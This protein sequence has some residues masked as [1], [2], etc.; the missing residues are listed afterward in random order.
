MRLN[1]RSTRLP[2]V[3]L[4]GLAIGNAGCDSSPD[5]EPSGFEELGVTQDEL[6]AALPSCSTAASSGYNSTTKLLTLTLGGGVS[7]VVIAAAGGKI[8]VNG[9]NCVSSA[10][11]SLTTLNVSKLAVTGTAANEKVIFDMLPGSFGTTILS[12]TGGVTVDMG[13]GTDSFMVRGTSA[14]DKFVAGVSAA[15]DTYFDLTNDTKADI[16][17]IGSDSFGISLLGGADTFTAV[18]GA[19]SATHLSATVS[20]LTPMTTG[21]TVYGGDGADTIQ[22]GDGDDVLYGG[23]GDDTFKSAATDDGSDKMF[24]E[25]GVDLVDYSN[26]STAVVVDIG[27]EY[28]TQ[29]G[30]VDLSTLTFGASGTVDGDDLVIAVD[31][32]MNVTVS[33]SAPADAAAVVSQINAAAGATVASLSGGSHL[34]LASTTK[35]ATSSIQVVSGT[36]GSLVDLGLT[37]A[38]KTLADADDGIAGENDDV[39]FTVEKVN[40]GSGNDTIYGS[41]ASNTINGNSGND[42]LGGGPGAASCASDVDVLN[43]GDGNDTFAMGS[44]KDCGDALNGGAGTDIADYQLRSGALTITIDMSA[45]DGEAMEGDKV[46]TDIEVVLGGSAGDTITGGMG[47]DEIHGG[48]GGDTLNGG[49]GNDTL[50]G[51]E[52]NDTLNGDAGDDLFVESGVDASYV[53]TVNSGAGDDVINGGLGANTVSYAL[54]TATIDV[55]LCSDPTDNVGLPT[56]TA[57]ACTDADGEGAE[58]DK[59]TNLQWVVGGDGDDNLTGSSAAETFEGGLGI[60]TIHG[61]GGDDTIYGEGGDDFLFGDDGDDYLEGGP[62]DDAID[63]GLSDGDVCMSDATDVAAVVACE[64]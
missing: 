43:G 11:A 24:G 21:V 7:T 41:S 23:P 2:L 39:D 8:S 32:G 49:G 1:R 16:R 35:T 44:E 4:V 15:G 47:N 10:G 38:T 63:G 20:S 12:T 40:G 50:V 62:G 31:G 14:A 5:Y 46:S 25:A 22:G 64:L 56:S 60:D 48:L 13:T 61:G 52:G 59:L 6:G 42:I 58:A 36:G 17:V 33:F 57:A 9:W 45:T 34:V 51:G 26:R 19:I 28:P 29:R 27:E 55:T 53:A 3:A 54:R 18:G 37:A 30:T